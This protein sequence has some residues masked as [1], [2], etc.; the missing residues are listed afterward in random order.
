MTEPAWPQE[1]ER[2]RS[3]VLS[4]IAAA[5]V[6]LSAGL[7][8]IAWWLVIPPL[9]AERPVAEPSPLEHGLFDRATGGDDARAAAAHRLDGYSWVDRGAGIVRIPIERAIDAV[10]ADPR[11][12]NAPPPPPV[13]TGEVGR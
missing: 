8:A 6:L 10:V 3:G 11:L 9:P 5:V 13:V 1:A 12:I 7:I 2:I 4:V